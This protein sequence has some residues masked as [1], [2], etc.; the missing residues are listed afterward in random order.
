MSMIQD[1]TK[2]YDFA[3]SRT[4]ALLD[5]VEKEPDPAAAL[6]WRPGSGRANVGWQLMHIAVSEE[7]FA[8]ERLAPHKQGQ[9]QELWPRYR[10]GSTPEDDVP[11]PAEIREKLAESHRQMLETLSEYSDQRLDEIPEAFRERGWNVRTVLHLIAWHEAH[12]QGQAHLTLNLYRAAVQ[13]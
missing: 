13:K 9:W 10:G 7:I 11:S 2:A 5:T 8:T 12:H 4:L 1:F 3:R 6:R